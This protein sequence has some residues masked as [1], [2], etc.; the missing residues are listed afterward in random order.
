[1]RQILLT[2]LIILL[3]ILF[4]HLALFNPERVTLTLPF[5]GRHEDV[6]VIVIILGSLL[7]GILISLIVLSLKRTMQFFQKW[8]EEKEA[9]TQR[10]MDQQF[11]RGLSLKSQGHILEAAE[12]W[13]SVL[14]QQPGHLQAL[15]ALGDL[16]AEEKDWE[17]A[18]RYHSK[19]FELKEQD[20]S[21]GLKLERDYRETGR[22][23]D[24][25][26]LLHRLVKLNPD[27]LEACRRQC[28]Y[29]ME[30]GQW[31][32]ALELQKDLIAQSKNSKS[33]EERTILL[34]IKTELAAS[35]LSDG[36]LDEAVKILK[37]VLKTDKG[38]VPAAIKLAEALSRQGDQ[39]NAL[40]ILE[41]SYRQNLNIALMEKIEEISLRREEPYRAIRAYKTV[42]QEYPQ[43][44]ELNLFLGKFY[45]KL[46]ML[47]EAQEQFQYLQHQGQ[48]SPLLCYLL[49]EV[50]QHKRQPE[51]ACREYQKAFNT[52]NSW[53]P[54]KC[55]VCAGISP[56]WEARCPH[57]QS[58][59]SLNYT[60]VT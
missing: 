37:D 7:A 11:Q 32:K 28:R 22:Y 52:L 16:R 39:E 9:K 29:Y 1:M 24:A 42:I 13:E 23:E 14:R 38:F 53:Q 44:Y 10:L 15:T 55:T 27:N 8:L 60:V 59:N 49:A 6:P 36:G 48:D 12:Q 17:Q 58:W 54:Y 21:L 31:H 26:E 5:L 50:Y 57:C 4:I 25:L 47:D 34:G 41:K 46:E 33:V 2:A 30:H 3:I 45:L 35:L 18:A 20:E 19:A 56:K 43:N 51:S 40:D